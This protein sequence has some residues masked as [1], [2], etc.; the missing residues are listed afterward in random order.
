MLDYASASKI[1]PFPK[2]ST[3]NAQH[4]KPRGHLVGDA[5][6]KSDD[7]KP[8]SFPV[9]VK[10]AETSSPASLEKTH[11]DLFWY[12]VHGCESLF[13]VMGTGCESVKRGTT[14]DGKIMVTGTWSGGLGTF[15]PNASKADIAATKKVEQQI[16]DGTVSDIP[17]TLK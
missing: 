6:F 2:H 17:T 4:S 1:G 16:A 10:S 13:T 15:S 14:A 8:S 5:A 11:P 12:G 7:Y 9:K 3:L